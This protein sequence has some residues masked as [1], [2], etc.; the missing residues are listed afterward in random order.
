M[1]EL[2]RSANFHVLKERQESPTVILGPIG[3]SGGFEVKTLVRL[4]YSI[5]LML[6]ISPAQASSVAFSN[7]NSDGSYGGSGNW[8][9]TLGS[10]KGTLAASFVAEQSGILAELW[11]GM[12]LG[13]GSNTVALKVFADD[14]GVM[15]ESVLWS[16]SSSGQLGASGS[17]L[18]LGNLNGLLV[19]K[20]KTYWLASEAPDD[21]FTQ[22]IWNRSATDDPSHYALNYWDSWLYFDN[23]QNF[24]MQL[25]VVSVPLPGTLLLFASGLICLP[26]HRWAKGR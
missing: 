26:L 4:F 20:G 2:L 23:T 22:L 8:F 1:K 16:V 21:G 25:S 19:E 13:S 9:G 14:N 5:V 17:L 10:Q 3:N 7:L 15:G 24:A 18:H 12:F 6:I 11:L